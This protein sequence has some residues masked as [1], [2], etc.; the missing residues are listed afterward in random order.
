[1]NQIFETEYGISSGRNIYLG[2]NEDKSLQTMC[3]ST[4][5]V[6]AFVVNGNLWSYHPN[7]DKFNKVF[8]FDEETSEGFREKNR[9][10][11]IKIIHVDNNGDIYFVVYGYMNR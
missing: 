10:Y 2:I 1:M 8:S 6:T 11:G 7:R 4:G 5:T 3:N 9:N